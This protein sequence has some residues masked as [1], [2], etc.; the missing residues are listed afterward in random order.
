MRREFDSPRGRALLFVCAHTGVVFFV[1][2]RH[3]PIMRHHSLFAQN[4]LYNTRN[5]CACHTEPYQCTGPHVRQRRENSLSETI[6]A[7]SPRL[8]IIHFSPTTQKNLRNVPPQQQLHLSAYYYGQAEEA[9]SSLCAH[10][11]H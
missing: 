7:L 5:S 4:N 1:S 8:L 11:S 6:K 10:R 3:S 2:T 9:A